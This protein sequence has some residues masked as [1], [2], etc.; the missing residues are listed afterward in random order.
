[1]TEEDERKED[2][3]QTPDAR[4]LA[5]RAEI[6][7][8]D[9]QILI[10]I[11][12]RLLQGKRIGQIKEETDNPVLDRSREKQILDR[13]SALNEGPL[14]NDV[15]QH[16]FSEMMAA[17]RQIQQAEKIA[18]LG[19]EATFT[20][21]AAME[22][23]GRSPLFV[24]QPSIQDVFVEVEKQVCDYGVVPVENSSEGAV[25]HTLDLFVE[26]DLKI[27]AEIYQTVSH[28]LLSTSGSRDDVRTVYSHP[29]ALAQCRKW[30][31]KNIPECTLQECS[32]TTRAAQQA[33]EEPGSAAIASSEAARMY[34]LRI[35]A[36]RIEDSAGNTTRFLIIGKKAVQ[37]TGNDKTSIM[38]VTAHVPGALYR[39]MEPIAKAD[40][41]MLKLESRPIKS[42]NWNYCFFVDLE[43]HIDNAE[44]DSTV[45]HLRSICQHLKWLG[46]Y[47]RS[48][49]ENV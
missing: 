7:E 16:L 38:F 9:E 17:S 43:G 29:Q 45:Q 1:M 30:L 47:P 35:V 28:D 46:S 27:C 44:V 26:S 10:L 4:I 12:R 14:Q 32:S 36:S 25:N 37:E 42:A 39:V 22:H 21:I 2:S 48:L 13:L 3:P 31:R 11:N 23:F 6:D 34:G 33:S 49:E 19:P 15:L 20:H 41:N 5:L 18:Y 24:P 8:I 40:I